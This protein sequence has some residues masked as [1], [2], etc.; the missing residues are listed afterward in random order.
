MPF[1]VCSRSSR[2]L[3]LGVV[4]VLAQGAAALPA[5]GQNPTVAARITAVENGLAPVVGGPGQES[6]FN[7]AD[8]MTY[9]GVPGISIAI[10]NDSRIEW[11]R[12][13]GV[14]D[15]SKHARVDTA[16]LFQAASIS[17]PQIGRAHV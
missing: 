10:I 16:S 6:R 5:L 17:K 7:I 12:G 9:Y 15:A 11:A 3:S 8:R 4:L 1:F 2:Q 13:Y 14:G